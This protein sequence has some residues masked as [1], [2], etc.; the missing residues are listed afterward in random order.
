MFLGKEV[1]RV[2]TMALASK[3]PL[4]HNNKSKYNDEWEVSYGQEL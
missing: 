3:W 1:G 2:E 4:P